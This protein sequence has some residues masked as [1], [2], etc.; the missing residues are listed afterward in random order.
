MSVTPKARASFCILAASV[1]LVCPAL[2]EDPPADL[3]RRVAARESANE[4]ARA[5]YMYRQTVEVRDFAGEFR[6]VRDVVFT[7]DGKRLEEP[8]GRTVNTLKRLK[9]TDE[10]VRDIRE[11]QPVLITRDNAFLYETK[12]RGEEELEGTMCWLIEIRPRQILSGQRY[13][14][15]TLWV[16]KSDYSVIRLAGRAVPQIVTT[17][18]EN[19]FPRFTTERRK[20]DGRFWFPISTSA[21][22]VLQF[23]GGPVRMRLA[24]RYADYRRFGAESR[25]EFQ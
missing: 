23:R 1:A 21:D 18:S 13:F 2:A 24:I 3:L 19:L 8:V 25:I 11:I 10:D 7:P 12:Y 17:K 5:Q 4:A 6:E 9:L 22:D 16:D 14:E 20:V 15:G